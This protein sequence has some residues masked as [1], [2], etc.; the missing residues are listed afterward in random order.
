MSKPQNK[1]L[2]GVLDRKWNIIQHI[3]SVLPTIYS[4]TDVMISS[5]K[6]MLI[7]WQQWQSSKWCVLVQ[8]GAGDHVLVR[9]TLNKACFTYNQQHLPSS[10]AKRTG[11]THFKN[12][13]INDLAWQEYQP[14]IWA[15]SLLWGH[16]SVHRNAE[17]SSDNPQGN[18]HAQPD[19][20]SVLI[21]TIRK[22]SKKNQLSLTRLFLTHQRMFKQWHESQS[23]A[24]PKP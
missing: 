22:T 10:L 11:I 16:F 2:I 15:N 14:A 8:S 1:P 6:K 7:L 13:F 4:E 18:H 19:H 24:I 21:T 23:L 12:K 17:F 3:G 5:G 9:D 20:I